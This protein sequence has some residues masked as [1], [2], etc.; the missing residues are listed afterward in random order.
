MAGPWP[1][2]SRARARTSAQAGPGVPGPTFGGPQRP[3]E[4]KDPTCSLR[5]KARGIPETMVY[6]I[7][8]SYPIHRKFYTIYSIPKTFFFSR[9]LVLMWAFGPLHLPRS[10]PASDRSGGNPNPKLYPGHIPLTVNQPPGRTQDG[11]LQKHRSPK[12]DPNIP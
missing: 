4:L 9:I 1:T 10:N 12:T 8:T 11:S 2:S 5:P 6:G 3:H 7:L